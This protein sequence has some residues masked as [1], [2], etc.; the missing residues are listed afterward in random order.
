MIQRNKPK[1]LYIHVPFCKSI[2]AYCDFAHQVY[3]SGIVEKWLEA[4][5]QEIKQTHINKHLK[6][7]YIG[8]GTPTSL[9]YEQLDTFLTY[10]DPYTNVV[11]EYTIEINPETFDEQKAQLLKQHRIN[12]A[13]IG[14]QTSNPTLLHLLQR[15]HTYQDVSKTMQLLRN[16]GITNISLDI[17]YS[18]PQ[19]TMQML[20]DTLHDAFLLQPTHLSLYSLTIEENTVFAY[21]GYTP[22]D[23]D[24]EADMY[25]YICNTC[26]QHG[27]KQYEVS[28]FALEGCQSIHNKA[29]W[30][31]QDFYGIGCGASGKQGYQRYDAPKQLTKYLKNPMSK[32]ITNLTKEDAMFEAVMMGIRLVEGMNLDTF[33]TL[34]DI[35][36]L[37]IYGEK[38]QTLIQKGL[39]EIQD[40][41][42]RCTTKGYEIMN[43]ILVELL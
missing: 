4:I 43:S 6:T 33:H 37:D 17:M 28:N 2:C 9:T 27:Y 35:S 38:I 29:Y 18:L 21:K 24:T 25:E 1:Y 23:E 5:H 34:F 42:F 39:V 30:N 13:S 14:L 20:Q 36:F 3:Q 26:N 8:G 10:L 12:R 41:H 40:H 11:Q 22:L 16:V 19:Q 31:Y 32:Q 15:K 7:I